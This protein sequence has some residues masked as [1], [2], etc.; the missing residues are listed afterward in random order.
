MGGIDNS[1]MG[2]RG[3]GKISAPEPATL[4][5]KIRTSETY[6]S[7]LEWGKARNGHPEGTL[8]KHLDLLH[9]NLNFI[10][11]KLR[12]GP[13]G[14]TYLSPEQIE[15]VKVLIDAHD[16]MKPKAKIGVPISH[17]NSHASLAAEWLRSLD[18]PNELILMTQLHDESHA[19]YRMSQR[20]DLDETR[21]QRLLYSIR[22]WDT[23]IAFQICDKVV[24]GRDIDSIH[25]LIDQLDNAGIEY[26]LPARELIA[27]VCRHCG[28]E[29]TGDKGLM[30]I[31]LN[32]LP[33]SSAI[34]SIQS[35]QDL[36]AWILELKKDI[37]ENS[38]LYYQSEGTTEGFLKL[39]EQMPV[40]HDDLLEYL[41]IDSE[42]EI[43]Y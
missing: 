27:D 40:T 4:H 5:Q 23:F 1:D 42:E 7:A 18:A 2:K 37:D 30:E 9:S 15:R 29:N 17:R 41:G 24:P 11:D 22:D 16:T 43:A 8:R 19:L 3:Q 31:D 38:Q 20:G 25:F 33:G 10:L 36:N 26:T 21:L 6:Q 35:I 28:I 39:T 34:Q 32:K 13:D 14:S 12:G